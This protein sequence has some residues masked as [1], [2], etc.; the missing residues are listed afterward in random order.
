M[1]T[2]A[3]LIFKRLLIPLV[4]YGGIVI[5]SVLA[6]LHP[7][8]H[9]NFIFNAGLFLFVSEFIALHSSVLLFSTMNKRGKL[10]LF[11]AY[12]LLIVAFAIATQ[13]LYIGLLFII[14]LFTKVLIGTTSDRSKQGI[15]ST[16][17]QPISIFLGTAFASVLLAPIITIL[18]PIS[19]SVMAHKVP[20]S[21]GLFVDTPQ[22]LLFWI[23]LYYTSLIVVQAINIQGL[24]FTNNKKY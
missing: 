3:P 23:I 10:T 11:C 20:N 13:S 22:V 6:A 12:S 9:I 21:S 7:E 5:F 19:E 8:D 16:F 15:G 17:I 4:S 14:S 1:T 2:S 18:I 24:R